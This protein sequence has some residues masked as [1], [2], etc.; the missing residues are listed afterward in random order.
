[1]NRYLAVG[2]SVLAGAAVFEAALVPGIVIGAAAVFLP[3]YLPRRRK[4]RPPR[5]RGQ[6]A[7]PE[8]R[9]NVEQ[10]PPLA[11][12][13]VKQAVVKTVTFRIIVTSLDFTTNYIVLGE[14]AT[15]AGLSTFAL[16]A[17][18]V[19]Y[20]LH[21]TAWNYYHGSSEAPVTI[22]VPPLF[23]QVTEGARKE[24][25]M[26]RALAKTITFRTAATAMDFATTYAVIGDPVTAAG[27]SAV[28]FVV[29]PFVYIWHEMAWDYLTH[30]KSSPD[31]LLLGRRDEAP[32][33]AA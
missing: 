24:L 32:I 19:F 7:P 17:G 33:A 18:P 4:Q 10:P 16:V 15:A 26:S 5:E 8:D 6:I 31:M 9:S 28:G 12:F 30:A 1:V 23:G 13:A 14:L 20:F 27:L 29:G 22:A 3:E 11:G 21:E 25:T 2:L